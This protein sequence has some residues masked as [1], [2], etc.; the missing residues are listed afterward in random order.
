MTLLSLS[1]DPN[2][3][4]DQSERAKQAADDPPD[5]SSRELSVGRAVVDVLGRDRGSGGGGHGRFESLV[6]LLNHPHGLLSCSR[7]PACTRPSTLSSHSLTLNRQ[8][9]N[10]R[11]VRPFSVPSCASARSLNTLR[12]QPAHLPCPFRPRSLGIGQQISGHVG[13]PGAVPRFPAG[14][15]VG[16]PHRFDRHVRQRRPWAERKLLDGPGGRRDRRGIYL[17][18]L[19]GLTSNLTEPILFVFVVQPSDLPRL[20]SLDLPTWSTAHLTVPPRILRAIIL[21]PAPHLDLWL[22]EQASDRRTNRPPTGQ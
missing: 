18:T 22:W 8:S 5:R 13:G 11:P 9:T 16:S 21:K 17:L 4:D 20:A 14:R 2:D 6:H 7:Q 3:Q 1:P 15:P 12:T 10:S 19:S